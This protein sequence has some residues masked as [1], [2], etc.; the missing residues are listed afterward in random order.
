MFV[1][2]IAFPTINL[3]K[4]SQTDLPSVFMSPSLCSEES[5]SSSS[6]DDTLVFIPFDKKQESLGWLIHSKDW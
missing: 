4:A 2:L 6:E 3:S 1:V 5:S